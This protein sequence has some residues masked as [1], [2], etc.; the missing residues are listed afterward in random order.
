MGPSPNAV[1][2][3]IHQI[4]SGVDTTVAVLG[5]LSNR[6]SH[7]CIPG[8]RHRRPL[9]RLK[10][11]TLPASVCVGRGSAIGA[12]PSSL[13]HIRL[14]G[15]DCQSGLSS[16][17]CRSARVS[18]PFVICSTGDALAFKAAV[19]NQTSATY[20]G[21]ARQG[22]RIGQRIETQFFGLLTAHAARPGV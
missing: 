15:G 8:R 16:T 3:D 18:M 2:S 10:D 4:A 11:S 13:A 22:P 12:G 9:T 14:A 19:A 1:S 5:V 7:V 20:D 21:R 6:K 17:D